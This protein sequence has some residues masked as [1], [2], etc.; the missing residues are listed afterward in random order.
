MPEGTRVVLS[1]KVTGG[2][3][4]ATFQF[5]RRR[6]KKLADRISADLV[7]AR[8][9]NGAE[10]FCRASSYGIPGGSIDSAPL[11]FDIRCEHSRPF[12]CGPFS[13]ALHFFILS[14]SPSLRRSNLRGSHC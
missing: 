12:F 7:V 3:P 2:R 1:C 5:Y 4:P 10:F 14:D 8:A 11:K 6:P 13:L 9:D